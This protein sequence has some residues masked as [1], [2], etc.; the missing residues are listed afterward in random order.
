MPNSVTLQVT[1]IDKIIDALVFCNFIGGT[2]KIIEKDNELIIR[3]S[4]DMYIASWPR[5][6]D[7]NTDG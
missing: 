6:L 5:K 2:I 7:D 3:D 1:E 4:N